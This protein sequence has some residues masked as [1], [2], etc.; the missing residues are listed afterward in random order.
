MATTSQKMIEIRFLVR[1][2]GALTPPPM[3]DEPV[4]KIPLVRN[5]SV[6]PIERR[7]TSHYHA[8]PTTDNPMQ[9]PIPVEAQA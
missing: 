1:I 7:E 2:L 4:M 8:A 5:V 6:V 9:S 3:M